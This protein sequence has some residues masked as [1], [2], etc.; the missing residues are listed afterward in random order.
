MYTKKHL[1]YFSMSL[2]TTSTSIFF[3]TAFFVWSVPLFVFRSRF[4]KAVYKTGEWVINVKPYFRKELSALFGKTRLEGKSEVRVRNQ[5]RF[6]LVVYAM[7]LAGL[8]NS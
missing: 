4:R 6:Y 1:K 2:P 8:I 5:Y 3:F 7:I